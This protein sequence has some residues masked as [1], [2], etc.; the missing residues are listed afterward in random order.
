MHICALKSFQRCFL[1]AFTISS[2]V[3]FRIAIHAIR[4][5]LSNQTIFLDAA[6]ISSHS[7]APE[8]ADKISKAFKGEKVVDVKLEVDHERFWRHLLPAFAERCRNWKHTPNCKYGIHGKILIADKTENSPFCD[9]RLGS[10]PSGYLKDL[11]GFKNIAPHAVRV[12]IP[13]C[14]SSSISSS[15]TST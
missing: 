13:I 2:K 4:M 9:C 10:F 15:A 8:I 3:T 12:A 14:F 6:A 1:F 7:T 11:N 5:D